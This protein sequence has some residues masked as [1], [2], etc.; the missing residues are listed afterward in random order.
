MFTCS[1]SKL[2][3]E[4]IGSRSELAVDCVHTADATQPLSCVASAVCINWSLGAS[5]HRSLT[6]L[7]MPLQA[8]IRCR[9]MP[10]TSAKPENLV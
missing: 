10:D 8:V 2:A 4:F 5:V 9:V 7:P 3:T 6:P 1:V